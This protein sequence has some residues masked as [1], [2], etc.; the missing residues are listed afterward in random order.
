M[1]SICAGA[2]KAQI[3][4]Y[5]KFGEKLGLAFQVH[6][7]ILGIWGDEKNTGKSVHN[8]LLNRKKSLPVLFG[9]EA[10]GKFQ[11]N[12]EEW[13]VSSKNVREL[14]KSLEE[15]GAKI[16]AEAK[17]KELTNEALAAL[18]MATPVPEAGTALKD[19]AIELVERSH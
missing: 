17:T 13:T 14:A 18:K 10:K 8:D 1:G 3:K 11:K 5:S 12:W 9:L 2:N 7:D 4:A 15:D 16:M 19:L 6:D